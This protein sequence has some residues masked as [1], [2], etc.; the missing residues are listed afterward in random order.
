MK[1]PRFKVSFAYI[2]PN[3]EELFF[4]K[5]DEQLLTFNELGFMLKVIS[6]MKSTEFEFTIKRLKRNEIFT[7]DF[8][9]NINGRIMKKILK[10]VRN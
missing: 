8:D 6:P 1:N 3:E 9:E 5:L 10:I 2:F 4:G 7:V